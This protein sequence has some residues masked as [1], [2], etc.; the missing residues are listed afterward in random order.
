MSR[1]SA[2]LSG[3]LLAP[4]EGARLRA[5][6]EHLAETRAETVDARAAELRR[7]ERDLHDGAQARLV[8]LA[9]SLGMAEEEIDRDPAAARQLVAEARASASIAL[10]GLRGIQQRL[11]AF[12]D[13][14]ASIFAKLGLPPSDDDH[15]RVL[16]VLAYL[17]S[18]A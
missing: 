17:N 14:I 13:N 4:G 3:W 18:N 5:Q 8:S 2:R 16:A 12:D 10:S 6:M 11:A 7:I 1:G 9:M 15:R